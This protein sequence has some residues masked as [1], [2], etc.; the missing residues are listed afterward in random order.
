M[1][2][3]LLRC[4]LIAVVIALASGAAVA[5][6]KKPNKQLDLTVYDYSSAIRWGEFE[7][8]FGYIDPE[9]REEHPLSDLDRARYK[10][11][12]VTHYEVITETKTV[13]SDDRQVEIS[14]VNRNTQAVRTVSYH[15][16]WRW[17]PKAKTWWLTTGLPDITA[18]N[19]TDD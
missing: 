18:E 19:A 5:K 6:S 4:L 3:P 12:E 15:E 1:R 13:D 16:H 8:A 11:I 7:R 14:L 9:V 17:D 10:Q 2:I